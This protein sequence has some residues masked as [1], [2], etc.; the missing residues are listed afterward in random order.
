MKIQIL[1]FA[2]H[3]DDIELSCSGTL[4]LHHLKGYTTG[5]IDLTAGELGSRGSVELRRQEA[6]AAAEILGISVRENLQ[7]RDGFF[8]NNEDSVRKVIEAI[9][10][11]QPD[12]ILANALRDRHPDHGRAAQLVRD[13]CFYSGLVKIETQWE[14]MAQTPWRPKRV[15]H[16]IQDT[17]L[18]PDFIVDI[19]STFVAKAPVMPMLS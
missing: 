5:I 17:D 13:A 4:L 19:S 1:A 11:Y 18:V 7:L 8:Q 12:I 15:F 16:Y 14:G 2:A 3:P 9:R 10:R 6:K